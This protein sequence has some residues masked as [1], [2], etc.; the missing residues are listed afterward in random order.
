VPG[1]AH[2]SQ[3]PRLEVGGQPGAVSGPGGGGSTNT[4]WLS[5]N[6]RW[7]PPCPASGT[8]QVVENM[9]L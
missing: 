6:S 4:R 2:A 9:K 3:S 7:G 1:A 8:P 5:K